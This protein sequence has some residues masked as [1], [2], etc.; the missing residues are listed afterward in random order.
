VRHRDARLGAGQ[1]TGHSG[2]RVAVDEQH[3]GPLAR[4][5]RFQRGQHPRGLRG[6]GPAPEIELV[7]RPRQPQL[8]EEHARQLVV[9]VLAGVH[10]H[11][12]GA[13]AQAVGDRGGLHKLRPVSYDR[14]YSHWKNRVSTCLDMSTILDSV[15]G[16]VQGV[17]SGVGHVIWYV[18]WQTGG[19]TVRRRA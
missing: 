10:Q 16:T 19:Q 1:R 15:R 4:D 17:L 7:I 9:V 13:G 6:V 14:E 3:V 11:L 18:D 5:Q 2:V 12:L 8:V